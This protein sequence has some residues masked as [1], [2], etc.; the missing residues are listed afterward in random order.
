M[1]KLITK[2]TTLLIAVTMSTSLMAQMT[3]EFNTN[4]S[5]GTTI[6]LPLYGTVNVTVDWGDSGPTNAYTT[7]GDKEHT[8]SS[9]GTYTVT[10]TNSLTQ[11]GNNYT[12]YANSDKLTKV[13]SFGDLGLTSICGAF[14]NTTNLEQVP[15]TLPAA[16]TNLNYSFYNTGKATITGLDSWDVSN[17]TSMI[18]M[19]LNA[20]AFNQNIGSWTVS[21]V[22]SMLAMFKNAS[23]FNQNIGSWTVSSV[24]NMTEMFYGS[25]AF[26]Q[27]ISN[28]N[29]SNVTNMQSMFY[30]ASDFNQ[31]IGNWE[32]TGSTVGNV[33]NMYNMLCNASVFNQDISGWDV[34]EVTNMK[35]LFLGAS[36]FNQDIG[37]WVVSKVADMSFMFKNA[38]AFN[39]D[40]GDWV[41]SS[42]T[43]MNNMFI[44]ASAFNQD[45]SGW[46]V[47]KVENMNNMFR[48]ASAFNQPLNSWDISSVTNIGYIFY[49][50]SAFNQ[51][52]NSWD[53]SSVSGYPEFSSMFRSAIS[54]NQDISNWDVSNITDMSRMFYSALAFNQDISDWD[55][56]AVTNMSYM[57]RSARAFNQDISDWVVSAVENMSYMFYDADAF[58]QDISGWT[59]S[60]VTDMSYMFS[61]STVFN[62]PLSS[63]NVSNV[64]D[65]SYM[66]DNTPNFDQDLSSWNVSN[67]TDMTSMFSG[68]TLSTANYNNLLTGWNALELQN[69][70]TFSGGNSKYSPGAAATAKAN[71]ISTDTWT[72]TDGG[73]ETSITWDGSTDEDWDTGTNWSG[74]AVPITTSNVVIPVVGTT[75]PV[76]ATDVNADCNNLTVDNGASLT[77]QSILSATGSLIVNG[78]A[79]GDVI[80]QRYIA[81][82]T[83]A[84]HGWHLLSSPVASQAIRPNFVPSTPTVNEDFYSWDEVNDIWINTKSGVATWNSEFESTFTYGKGYLVAYGPSSGVSHQ[85]SGVPNTADITKSGLS[86]TPISTHTGWH[87]LGNPYPSALYWSKTSSWGRVNCDAIAKIWVES[88]AGYTDIDAIT[89]IIPAMQG[90]MVCASA[91]TGSLTIDASD[92]T[93]NN[94]DWYKEA[95]VNKIKLTVYDPEGSTAQESIIKFNENATEGFDS[96]YDSRFLSGYAPMLYSQAEGSNVSTN[97]LP[98]LKEELSI[99]LY[100]IKNNSSTFYIEAEG[101]DNLIPSYPVYLTDLQTNYTQNLTNNPVYSFTSEEGDDSQRFLLH[102]KAVGVEEQSPQSN[103]Q[104]WAANNTIHI[105]NPENSKGEIRILNMFGQQVAQAKLS[106]D[107]KQEIQLNV[108]TGCYLVNVV[109]EDRVVTK[110]VV[111]RY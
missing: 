52:L 59:V 22:T 51:P 48:N 41:V 77:I 70:V 1:K 4:L 61:N 88:S 101:L 7:T 50:A 12:S 33:I 13:T 82:W 97:T 47:S 40:I 92:R 56:S 10:I 42:V 8:F 106:G 108:P 54:F 17:V 78:S 62:K 109:S 55:V 95:E 14:I 89:G 81:D 31:N 100:F 79:A 87:L 21:S 83:D 63:W 43:D 67:V 11:F 68:I 111:I 96:E 15:T 75:Y 103:I 93:H 45:I 99:P 23:A 72:I 38:S 85:F 98:E 90:F 32:R 57:F 27:D 65:M 86:Y 53:V 104:A 5:D 28:W 91:S 19:F 110:K 94:K 80:M 6:T 66:F 36:A 26:D 3:L 29:V 9:G 2:L 71:I 60:D 39:Q 84:S 35:S 74:D 76:I 73:E 46:D 44:Y 24:T 18:S 102:F 64:T 69:D 105:L 25:S 16:I 58:N 49:N 37:D 107:T 20:S 30:G 34:S